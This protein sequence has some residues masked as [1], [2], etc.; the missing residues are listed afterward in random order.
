MYFGT[1]PCI[2][3]IIVENKFISDNF[4]Y[5]INCIQF[6]FSLDLDSI[7][8]FRFDELFYL[9]S[10]KQRTVL[11]QG[12][13]LYHQDNERYVLLMHKLDRLPTCKRESR[14]QAPPRF[15]VGTSIRNQTCIG[16]FDLQSVAWIKKKLP[17]ME[18]KIQKAY[19]KK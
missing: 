1:I 3:P 7:F 5:S 17:L 10:R 4:F 11:W 8:L 18:P 13:W 15:G 2:L 6:R 14:V 19:S 9:D 12:R 16:F